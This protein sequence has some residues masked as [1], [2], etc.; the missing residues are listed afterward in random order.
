LV[1]SKPTPVKGLQSAI[2]ALTAQLKRP[3]KEEEVAAKL[4]ISLQDYYRRLDVARPLAFVSLND[5]M[6]EDEGDLQLYESY[7]ADDNQVDIRSTCES[8]ETFTLLREK[9]EQMDGMPKK[10]LLLYYYK[11]L[12]LSEIATV[13]K[14]TESRICQIHTQALMALKAYF[15]RVET[16]T[17]APIF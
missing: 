17:H 8:N 16:G 1:V 5:V 4:G 11:G 13:L 3:P 9:I 14:L 6:G 15:K 7:V 10:V 12:R 2:N